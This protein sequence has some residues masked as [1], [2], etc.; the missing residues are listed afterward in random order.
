MKPAAFLFQRL[1]EP[2]SAQWYLVNFWKGSPTAAAANK[3]VRLDS[4]NL[5]TG[6]RSLGLQLATVP[7]AP[8]PRSWRFGAE[9]NCAPPATRKEDLMTVRIEASGSATRSQSTSTHSGLDF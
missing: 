1:R 3:M 8:R 2:Q 7:V 6:A 4:S 5:L 9:A